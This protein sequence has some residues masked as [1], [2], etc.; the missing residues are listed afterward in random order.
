MSGMARVRSR[1]RGRAARNA[2]VG[3]ALIAVLLAAL[4]LRAGIVTVGPVLP[5]V[6]G[7]LH[8]PAA[9]SSGLIS[10]PLLCFAA[11]SPIAPQL[12]RRLGL[13]WSV[14][15]ALLALAI[16]LIVRALPVAGLIWVGSILIGGGIAVL[17]VLLPAV[18]KRDFPSRVGQVTGLYSAMQG[19]FAA[20]AVAV[21]A[22]IAGLADQGWRYAL[23]WLAVPALLAFGMMLVRSVRA[24]E[25]A[26]ILP[27]LDPLPVGAS[28]RTP[29]RPWR[30]ALAWQVSAYMGLQSMATFMMSTWM[31]ALERQVG[32]SSIE[33]GFHQFVLQA[34][35]LVG[36][37]VTGALLHR[38]RDQRWLGAGST[39]IMAVGVFGFAL[40]PP[41]AVVWA[42]VIGFSMG[43]SV[44]IG[45]SLFGL[46]T[47]N[48]HEATSL[49]AMGQSIGYLIAAAGPALFGLLL[50]V[51]NGW[52]LPFSM[53]AVAL[54]LQLLTAVLAGRARHVWPE[55]AD[56]GSA[57]S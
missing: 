15:L 47:R 18:V 43:C 25:A 27:G 10:L 46:R 8:L 29:L 17:N 21:T 51:S 28:H 11:F 7:D 22:P 42:M 54:T 52:T 32:V 45:L 6:M 39:L 5:D 3:M 1:G 4:N 14:S 23:G 41:L 13:E 9:L 57:K 19:G 44:V 20:A 33:A 2:T 37:L 56:S 36:T 38:S 53:V 16:G 35:G 31:P 48:H 30:R 50:D 55:P 40:H 34:A 26:S 24:A 49:S 12:A